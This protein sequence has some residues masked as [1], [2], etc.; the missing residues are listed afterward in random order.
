[1]PASD[2]KM[3]AQLAW[4]ATTP[5]RRA[6]S[7]QEL[8]PKL[9]EKFR[10]FA[11][12]ELLRGQAKTPPSPANAQQ[13]EVTLSD[14]VLDGVVKDWATATSRSASSALKPGQPSG[15]RRRSIARS[16]KL[17]AGHIVASSRATRRRSG[18]MLGW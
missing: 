18:T 9:R 7:L 11:L 13:P 10:Q 15:R 14:K 16:P 8:D 12:E 2:L 17:K 3:Q 4:G 1:V 6:R 5:S